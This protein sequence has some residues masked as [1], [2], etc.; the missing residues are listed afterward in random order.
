ME[1]NMSSTTDIPYQR[2]FLKQLGSNPMALVIITVV[3]VIYY[4]LFSSLGLGTTETVIERTESP[5]GGIV[6]LEI[7]MW[8][9]FVLLILINGIMYMFNIDITATVKDLFLEKPVIDI[10]VNPDTET[11]ILKRPTEEV[12]HVSNNKYS[13]DDAKAICSAYDARLATWKDVD[14]AHNK[15]ADWCSMGWSDGQMALYPTQFDK[16]SKLQDIEGHEHDCGRPGINGGY[17]SNPNVKFGVNCFGFKPE[18]TQDDINTMK[19]SPIYPTTQ[20]EHV[21]EKKVDFWR[22]KLPNL[23]V[24]PFNHNNWSVL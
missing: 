8:S 9:I 15:G 4:I 11:A 17:I 12:F 19:M 1:V 22:D 23:L 7:I 16:W 21:F 2:D 20:R 24:S 14:S 13:Y 5:N 6:F 10:V 18:I 3:I